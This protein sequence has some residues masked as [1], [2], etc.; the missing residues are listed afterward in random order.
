MYQD[1]SDKIVAIE[2]YLDSEYSHFEYHESSRGEDALTAEPNTQIGYYQYYRKADNT[3]QWVY[4]LQTNGSNIVEYRF[5]DYLYT[6]YTTR[7]VYA[8]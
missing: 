5:E 3:S 2:P 6:E 7:V 4:Y 8:G 1:S